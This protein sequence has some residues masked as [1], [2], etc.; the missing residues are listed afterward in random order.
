MQSNSHK[1][2][3]KEYNTC[4]LTTYVYMFCPLFQT[5][6][7][8]SHAQATVTLATRSVYTEHSSVFHSQ[9]FQKVLNRFILFLTITAL[10]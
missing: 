2:T 5:R 4:G 9:L 8:T 7:A 6:C 3:I 1:A 10:L